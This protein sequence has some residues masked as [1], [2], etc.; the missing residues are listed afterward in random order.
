MGSCPKAA[1]AAGKKEVELLQVYCRYE[2]T[3]YSLRT[4]VVAVYIQRGVEIEWPRARFMYS[5][6]QTKN[7]KSGWLGFNILFI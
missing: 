4:V 6:G 2:C 3:G 1:A 7:G 5:R